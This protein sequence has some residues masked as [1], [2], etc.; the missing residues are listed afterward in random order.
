MLISD[1]EYAQNKDLCLE[2]SFDADTLYVNGVQESKSHFSIPY[3]ECLI[4]DNRIVFMLKQSQSSSVIK[5]EFRVQIPGFKA[6]FY[7]VGM[8]GQEYVALECK[9]ANATS[10]NRIT[11]SPQE[12]DIYDLSG[13]KIGTSKSFP[14]K[15]VRGSGIYIENGKKKVK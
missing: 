9:G 12:G 2:Y 3:A 5:K 13:R 1:W 6:G 11:S 14:L 8:P 7:E 15:G 10:V 4:T